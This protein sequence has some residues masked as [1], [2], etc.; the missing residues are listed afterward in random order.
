[1]NIRDRKMHLVVLLYFLRNNAQFNLAR[2]LVATLQD[3][4]IVT[5]ML[6]VIF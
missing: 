5:P 6:I 2:E 4:I 1:M 3:G